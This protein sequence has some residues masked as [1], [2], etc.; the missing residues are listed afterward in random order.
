MK[1]TGEILDKL[2]SASYISKIDLSL[3]FHQIPLE[4]KG[5]NTLRFPSLA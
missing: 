1:D 3:A 5:N 2:R 4:D